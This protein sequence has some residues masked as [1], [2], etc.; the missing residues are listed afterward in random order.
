MRGYQTRVDL[1]K[2]IHRPE[3][4]AKKI[5]DLWDVWLKHCEAE[6]LEPETIRAYRQHFECHIKPATAPEAL[7]NGWKGEF[8]NLKLS[9]SVLTGP[10]CEAFRLR[11]AMSPARTRAREFIP[12]R[13]IAWT[14][15]QRIWVNFKRMLNVA[16][17]HGLI[18]YNPARDISF[19]SKNREKVRI[20]IGE[21]IPDRPDVRH[22]LAASTGI[23]LVMFFLDSFSGLRSSELRA[24]AWSTVYLDR[25]EIE[26]V[27]RA[28]WSGQIGPC[29]SDSAKRT[30]QIPDEVV[31]VLR[32]WKPICPPSPDD[33]VFPDDGGNVIP[34]TK[35][36]NQL[37][38][39]QRRIGMVRPNNKPKEKPKGK[40]T[41]HTLRH[42]YASIMIA[43]RIDMKQLQELL[44]HANIKITMDTYGHLF[45][46]NEAQKSRA[47]K[48]LVAVFRSDTKDAGSPSNSTITGPGSAS[49]FATGAATAAEVPNPN[50]KA[51]VR[52]RPTPGI[53]SR[54]EIGE[55]DAAVLP[56]AS[57]QKIALASQSKLPKPTPGQA[58][59]ETICVEPDLQGWAVTIG[60]H[61]LGRYK[62]Y[63]EAKATVLKL[64]QSD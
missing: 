25:G 54:R 63:G 16:V 8:G 48:A 44:G 42:F 15:A 45:P 10:V 61:T 34:G 64:V 39:V 11:L 32:W 14:T 33:L 23:W 6:R 53:A 51:A 37:Y 27:R 24:L 58:V 31:D 29:K 62:T 46:D 36:L 13:P 22:I 35:I 43:E 17:K 40:Y 20:R 2:G 28:D 26:V 21:Q 4:T 19:E 1:K 57:A 50:S 47:N 52:G 38:E 9:L 7:P 30:I 3:S 56:G 59:N 5:S 41:V 55:Q 60:A 12:N 49:P 18:A